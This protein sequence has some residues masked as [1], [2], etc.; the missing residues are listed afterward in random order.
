MTVPLPTVAS[1]R[2]T[3]PGVA[4]DLRASIA[5]DVRFDALTRTIFA[6][7]ASIYEIVPRGVVFPRNTKDVV[8]IVRACR[9]H[10]ENIVPRGAG[11]GLA[12]GAVGAGIQVDFS[13]FMN[14]VG[15]VD[16]EGQTVEVEPGVVLDELNAS[17]LPNGLK[18]APDVA[19]SSRATIGG[20]IA[21]NSCGAG[22]VIYGR[23]VDHV[24]ELVKSVKI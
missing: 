4:A 24:K 16:E 13:R 11:T 1:I 15:A 6:T 17:L 5:G 7:D 9:E 12:G 19:T 23:T 10:G 8:E 20:M 22:S 3:E 21:N 2:E 14:R 18:F